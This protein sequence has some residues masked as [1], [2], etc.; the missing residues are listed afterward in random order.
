MTCAKNWSNLTANTEATAKHIS[1]DLGLRVKII[2]KMD[3]W[4]SSIIWPRETR[5]HKAPEQRSVTAEVH[6]TQD[7]AT[8]R[9]LCDT[10]TYTLIDYISAGNPLWTATMVSTFMMT[11][12]TGNIFRVTGPFCGNSPVIPHTKA[13]DADFDVFCAW[14]NGWVTIMRLTIWDTIALIM[15]SL[16]WHHCSAY[17]HISQV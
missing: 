14:I 5:L 3:P 10:R 1:I 16:L 17:C 15:T 9:K 6:T 12:S 13:S 11:S 2:C 8:E 7:L 4:T